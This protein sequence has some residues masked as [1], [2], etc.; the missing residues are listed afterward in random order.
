MAQRQSL[1]DLQERLA[2]RLSAA[3]TDASGASWLAVEVA[4]RRYLLPLVQSGE[5]FSWAPVQPVPYTRPWYMGVAA[6]RGGLHGVVDLAALAGG[7]AVAPS[8]AVLDRVTSDSRLISLHPAL[9]VNAVLW[10]DKL[11]GLRDPSLFSSVVERAE[12]APV[13]F[14]RV[15]VDSQGGAWQELN[16]QILASDPAFLDITADVS[17]PIF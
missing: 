5:I 16:L 17:A 2:R 11:L 9:D 4:G 13:F 7:D 12:G 3:K 10:V 1:R 14:G 6:L 15:L 8:G